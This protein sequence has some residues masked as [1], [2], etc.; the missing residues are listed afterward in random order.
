MAP[1]F[2]GNDF[3]VVFAQSSFIHVIPSGNNNIQGVLSKSRNIQ[4]EPSKSNDIQGKASQSSSNQ[5]SNI[6]PIFNPLSNLWSKG[7][8]RSK[9]YAIT[10]KTGVLAKSSKSTCST[11]EDASS[12]LDD[13][14]V[15]PSVK[16]N[17]KP[18]TSQR[19]VI[20]PASSQGSHLK[21]T[22]RQ[23]VAEGAQKALL[24]GNWAT[25]VSHSSYPLPKN[26]ELQEKSPDFVTFAI[27]IIDDTDDG[28][29]GQV[30]SKTEIANLKGLSH[31]K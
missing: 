5:A 4:R 20:P 29:P 28:L 19:R 17:L 21:K 12:S 10:S 9:I 26:E 16:P 15:I 30:N 1:T 3:G 18:K 7:T 11:V 27:D 13:I 31:N 23:K 2:I 24:P 6:N 14:K 22:S 25:K 8:P